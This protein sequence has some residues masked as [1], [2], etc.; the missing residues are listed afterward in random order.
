MMHRPFGRSN[1]L[2]GD[3]P[4]DEKV[5]DDMLRF[6]AVDLKTTTLTTTG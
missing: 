4:R 2:T 6:F 1:C 3:K 5:Q